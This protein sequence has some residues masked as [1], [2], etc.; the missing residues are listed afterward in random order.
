MTSK[1]IGPLPLGLPLGPLLPPP[2][3][4][5]RAMWENEELVSSFIA[6]YARL[7]REDGLTV[8]AVHSE[9]CMEP[10]WLKAKYPLIHHMVTL[11][12]EGA[13]GYSQEEKAEALMGLRAN[14]IAATLK[15]LGKVVPTTP[16]GGPRVQPTMVPEVVP[17]ADDATSTILQGCMSLPAATAAAAPRSKQGSP[18]APRVIPPPWRAPKQPPTVPTGE[19]TV[20]QQGA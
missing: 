14:G 13:L 19:Q 18:L 4:R 10:G 15:T 6:R 16:P 2:M 1:N 8:W 17:T 20:A 5:P 12:D 7:D 9:G 3:K 11:I